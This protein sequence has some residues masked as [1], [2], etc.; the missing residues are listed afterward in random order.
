MIYTGKKLGCVDLPVSVN[1][2][3]DV[4]V[5]PRP[6]KVS[7][8][9]LAAVVVAAPRPPRVNPVLAPVPPEKSK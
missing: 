1:P 3:L 9:G 7:P 6:P 2:V 8:P 5:P 4:V